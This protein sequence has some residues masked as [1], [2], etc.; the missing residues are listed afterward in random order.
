MCGI[1]GVLKH[2]GPEL[3]CVVSKM[4]GAIRYR[5]PDNSRVWSGNWLGLYFVCIMGR[6]TLNFSLRDHK[7]MGSVNCWVVISFNGMR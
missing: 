5:G 2:R 4:V 6:S 3:G 7:P 1:A